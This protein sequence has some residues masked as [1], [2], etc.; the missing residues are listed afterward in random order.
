MRGSV[1]VHA[2]ISRLG[3]G[4]GFDDKQIFTREERKGAARRIDLP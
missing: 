4:W 1:G 3:V 2:A